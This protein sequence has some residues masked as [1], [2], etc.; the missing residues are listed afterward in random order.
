M[1]E[2]FENL[3]I[4]VHSFASGVLASILGYFLPIKDIV[5]LIIIFFIIDVVFGYLAARKGKKGEKE[6]FSVKIIWNHTMPRLLISI[7]IILGAYSWDKTFE[8]DFVA[9]YKLIGWF[10]SG[11]LLFSIVEN[12]YHITK[13]GIL[14]RIGEMFKTKIKDKTGIN[15]N[16]EE[17]GNSKIET[18][19]DS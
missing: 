11:V 14:P 7:I 12:G 2:F 8:Q 1:R 17:N 5:H 3:M 15:I 4:N 13:W 10:I 19:K 16:N 9:T 18:A 6:R